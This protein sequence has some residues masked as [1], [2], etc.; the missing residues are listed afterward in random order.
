MPVEYIALQSGSGGSVPAGI[1][2]FYPPSELPVLVD[3]SCID[4]ITIDR[5][6]FYT[7]N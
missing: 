2:F 5:Y 6:I 3:I 4:D 7:A 1:R